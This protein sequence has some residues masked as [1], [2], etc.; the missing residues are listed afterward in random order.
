MPPE[1]PPLVRL[2]AALAAIAVVFVAY[3]GFAAVPL[4]VDG[5]DEVV[6]TGTTVGDLFTRGITRAQP[7]DLVD[8]TGATV[9]EAGAGL[10]PDVL[11]DGRPAPRDELLRPGAVVV[12]MK[13]RNATE[14][15][16]ATLEAIAIPVRVVGDGPLLRLEDPGAVGV[17]RVMIGAVSGREVTSTIVRE[18][19]TMVF[20]RAQPPSA[21]KVVALTFDDGPWPGQ[22][23]KILDIL[24]KEDVKATFF[25]VGMRAGR[26]PTLARRVAA[27]GHLVG[28]HTYGHLILTRSP[29]TVV[30]RQI[31]EGQRAVIRATGHTPHWFRP[32]G[33][34]VSPTVYGVSRAWKLRFALWDVDPADWRRRPSRFIARDVVAAARP[35]SVVLL[36]DGGG[37][38]A[39]TINALPAIIKGLRAKGYTLVTLDGMPGIT[40]AG[41]VAER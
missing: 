14:S 24:K 15:L 9:L 22:T 12:T 25:M 17:L 21:S 29:S 4:V 40:P 18:P 26:A 34:G 16:V 27:E 33:G 31:A 35:G 37:D 1:P 2:A 3:S 36:H 38:R 13:G 41:R 8:A 5:R 23:E 6:R 39:Q 19:T 11:V 7:G 28:N 10:P 32:P 20:R 30:S